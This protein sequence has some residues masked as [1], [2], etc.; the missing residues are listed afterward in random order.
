MD[1]AINTAKNDVDVIV[2]V[3]DGSKK[4]KDSTLNTLNKYTKNNANVILVV[5]SYNFFY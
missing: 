5:I 2:Y 3:I 4:I 1:K